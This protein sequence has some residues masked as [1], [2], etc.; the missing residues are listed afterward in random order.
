MNILFLTK[1]KLYTIRLLKD[2]SNMGHHIVVVCK[3]YDSFR[4]TQMEAFCVRQGIQFFDDNDLYKELRDD[5][6]DKFDIAISNTYGR[7]IHRELIEWLNGNIINLHCA[8]LPVYKGTFVYNWGLYNRETE[9]GVTAHYINEKFDEGDIIKIEK[10]QIDPMQSVA[11]LERKSQEVAYKLT[12]DLLDDFMQGRKPESRPQETGGNYYSRKCFERLKRI[13]PGDSGEEIE[14]KYHA[15]WCPP[16]E[17]AYIEV[18]GK[19]YMIISQEH[20]DC[21]HWENSLLQQ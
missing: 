10:F 17:G 18:C 6:L 15:C 21:I 14:K 1:S 12:L 20:F 13:E 2:L 11:E 9:W 19:K 3:D 7:L 16:Y 4:N 8:I 5:K